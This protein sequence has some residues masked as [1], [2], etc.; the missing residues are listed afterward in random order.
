MDTEFGW[1]TDEYG[2]CGTGSNGR[3]KRWVCNF[4]NKKIKSWKFELLTGIQKT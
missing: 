4:M 1:M 3:D 2:N